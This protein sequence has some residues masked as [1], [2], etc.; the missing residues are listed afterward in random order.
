MLKKNQKNNK[1]ILSYIAMLWLLY[2]ADSMLFSLNN[3]SNV[4]KLAQLSQLVVGFVLLFFI[5][6]KNISWRLTQ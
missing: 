2:V 6:K 3:N 1:G 5:I 4:M